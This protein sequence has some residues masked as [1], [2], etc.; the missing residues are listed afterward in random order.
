MT[1]R[2]VAMILLA[3]LMAGVEPALAQQACGTVA[4][5][6]TDFGKYYSLGSDI[7]DNEPAETPT[8]PGQTYTHMRYRLAGEPATETVDWELTLR[9][10]AAAIDT[11]SSHDLGG[12]PLRAVWTS[13]IPLG[14][15]GADLTYDL[16]TGRVPAGWTL[17]LQAML[18]MPS[19]LARPF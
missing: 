19:G 15:G 14:T 3:G 2:H 11:V 7:R 16:K 4:G 9:R 18:A 13:R 1:C 10:G 5:S 6:D 8:A 12:T 17:R